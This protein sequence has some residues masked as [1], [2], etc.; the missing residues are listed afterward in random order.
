MDVRTEVSKEG[1][2]RKQGGSIKT[3]KKRL[4]VL[5][6]S[7]LAYFEVDKTKG[8]I[9][10]GRIDLSMATGVKAMPRTG[11]G[12]SYCFRIPTPEREYIIAAE[13]EEER[14]GWVDKVGEAIFKREKITLHP[15]TREGE[16][17]TDEDTEGDE[18]DLEE[19]LEG[20]EDL[21][22]EQEEQE[23]LEELD[24]E[25]HQEGGDK[26]E[27]MEEMEEKVV[28]KEK[29]EVVVVGDRETGDGEQQ[30][31]QQQQQRGEEVDPELLKKAQEAQ[32]RQE[33]QEEAH[34]RAASEEEDAEAQ[35]AADLAMSESSLSS[36]LTGTR[37]GMAPED[38]ST[39]TSSAS[40]GVSSPVSPLRK[41]ASRTSLEEPR[42]SPPQERKPSFTKKPMNDA[43][44]VSL[45]DPKGTNSWASEV[46]IPLILPYP[47]LILSLSC[48]YPALIRLL[49]PDSF[50]FF[51]P[52]Y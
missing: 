17:H 2:L 46:S 30:Q 44:F 36:P 25:Q 28:E 47:P 31:Q 49:S 42:S 27:K 35:E 51:I 43:D 4:F 8:R 3:W 23:D 24:G 18:E 1:F 29:V 40:A 5:Q 39:S 9:L 11:N 33:A 16:V 50:P 12:A 13:T 19:D 38:P 26:V 45:Q 37:G 48:S 20:Q 10:K 6:G 15:A 21:E 14:G 41:A 52:F 32:G 7:D 34:H 22:G